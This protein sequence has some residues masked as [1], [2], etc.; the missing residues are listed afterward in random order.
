MKNE[1]IEEYLNNSKVAFSNKQFD[2]SLKWIQKALNENN[3]DVSVN[4]QAGV[5][6][7]VLKQFDKA[8]EYFKKA[9]EL[10]KKNGDNLF[11]L[12]NAYFFAKD[13][14]NALKYYSMAD[15]I[16]CSDE[17]KAKLYYQMA[18]ICSLN[19]NVQSALINYQKYEDCDSSN[20]TNSE[21][22]SQ[23]VKLYLLSNDIENA[24]NCAGQLVLVAPNDFKNYIIYSQI[25]MSAKKYDKAE[26]VLN[27]ALKYTSLN[28]NNKV[29]IEF[30]RVT[31][32]LLK[33]ELNVELSN[34]YYSKAL[35]LLNSL[36]SN[37]NISKSNLNEVLLTSAEI[38][39][40]LENY[41]KAIS[42]IEEIYNV[43]NVIDKGLSSYEIDDIIQNTINSIEDKIYFGEIDETEIRNLETS[44]DEND[45]EYRVIPEDAFDDLNS[46]SDKDNSNISNKDD[47]I[48]SN[49]FKD[50]M[51]FI[52]LSCYAEK[53]DYQKSL[54]YSKMLKHNDNLYYSYYSIYI[55]AFSSKQL[56][57][58]SWLNIYDEA[59][60]FFKTKMMKN[61]SDKLAVVF[62]TRL[63]AE[64]GKFAKAL[65]MVNLLPDKDKESILKYIEKYQKEYQIKL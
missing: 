41:D 53:E 50:K 13:Y 38:Y 52:L 9:V 46:Y 18:M 15:A 26:E 64:K 28:E 60:A 34:S 7:V 33:A 11:N 12:G 2:E 35:E 39:L 5:I 27:D 42:C 20:S 23:K 45:H 6:C 29:T 3:N 43:N 25:L 4:S 32:Y 8:M 49:D 24:L 31:L 54:S 51:L 10:D 61:P 21:V 65:E 1:V 56:L 62:R 44:Y 57:L 63:Y 36:K 14:S 17:A 59:I 47:I 22:I 16:G 40:K 19:G 37:K 55:E 30:N 58:N 48:L